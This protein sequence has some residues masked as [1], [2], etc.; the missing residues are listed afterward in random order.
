MYLPM[1]NPGSRVCNQQFLSSLG[2]S[3]RPGAQSRGGD[4][5]RTY[6]RAVC[7]HPVG[8]QSRGRRAVHGDRN[9]VQ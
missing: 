4:C 7:S 9:A 1:S 3:Q 6:L 5:L 2:I 8:Q